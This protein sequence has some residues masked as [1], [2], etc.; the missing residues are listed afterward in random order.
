MMQ[1]KGPGSVFSVNYCVKT[2][3]QEERSSSVNFII[4]LNLR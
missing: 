4:T 1:M 3:G 2:E